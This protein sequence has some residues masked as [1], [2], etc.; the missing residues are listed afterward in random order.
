MM[1]KIIHAHAPS[2]FVDMFE[3]QFGLAVYNLRSSIKNIQIP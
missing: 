1:H 3:K 2:Y